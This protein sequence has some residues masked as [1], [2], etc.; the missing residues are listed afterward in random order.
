MA[1]LG[2][3]FAEMLTERYRNRKIDD[4]PEHINKLSIAFDTFRRYCGLEN[5]VKK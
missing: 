5:R 1:N 3:E 2:Q 4:I